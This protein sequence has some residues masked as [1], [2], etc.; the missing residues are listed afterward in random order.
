MNKIKELCKKFFDVTFWKFIIVGVI[1]TI[2]GTG[3]MFVFYNVFHFSYWVS[4]A[5]NYI[6]GS[7]VSYF[8][9]KY[10]TF[11]S[12]TN[13]GKTMVRFVVNISLCYLLAYGCAKPLAKWIFSGASVTVQENLAM[14]AGMCFFVALNYIGQRFFVFKGT[15]EENK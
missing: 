3:V 10:F 6:V 1:N 9:N 5:S 13:T 7:V 2:V 14:L 12:K 4:S 11:K 8:L 15:Q